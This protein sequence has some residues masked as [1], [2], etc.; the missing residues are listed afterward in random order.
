LQAS[1]SP[2]PRIQIWYI[3]TKTNFQTSVS[4]YNVSVL[5]EELEALLQAPE[6]ALAT[7]KK[8]IFFFFNKLQNLANRILSTQSYKF[9]NK[10][11]HFPTLRLQVQRTQT[12]G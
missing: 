10:S 2:T 5:V 8:E 6:T 12:T 3:L 4:Y 1:S 9:Y 7:A 11:F